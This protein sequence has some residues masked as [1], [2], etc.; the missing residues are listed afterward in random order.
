MVK[1]VIKRRKWI[2]SLLG[3]FLIVL[4]VGC[5]TTPSRAEPWASRAEETTL[6]LASQK[7]YGDQVL[8]QETLFIY[9]AVS[10]AQ[11]FQAI[12]DRFSQETGCHLTITYAN[13]GQI[14][15]QIK[16][17]KEGDLFIAA[18]AEDL[19]SLETE[20]ESQK[21][22]V[23]HLPVLVVTKGNPWQ[24]EKL[25]DLQNEKI[26]LVL[27]DKEAT[28]IGIVADKIFSDLGLSAQINPVA[29]TLS[30]PAL[31]T[32][33]EVG[34]AD[35]AIA[36]K[37]NCTSPEIELIPTKE[38][39]SYTMDV[40]AAGLDYSE[41]TKARQSFLAYLDQAETKAI[42]KEYGYEE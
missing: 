3:L 38:L 30:A 42:W 6:S 25:E 35:A 36:W 14:Q 4:L 16:M 22:L 21:V 20:I 23:K 28:S 18:A 34:E 19:K 7:A 15:T 33:L 5:S 24:I 17:T 32:A 10:L 39:S 8:A 40:V 26:R 2:N 37:E 31:V 1:S 27:G 9:C 12:A 29:T 11:P 41:N 13:T